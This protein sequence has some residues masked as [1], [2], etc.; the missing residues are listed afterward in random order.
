MG[1]KLVL[2]YHKHVKNLQYNDALVLL[3][4]FMTTEHEWTIDIYITYMYM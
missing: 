4:T 1:L 3:S 2:T